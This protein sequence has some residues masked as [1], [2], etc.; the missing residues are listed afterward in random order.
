MELKSES[1]EL[2][3]LRHPARVRW[4]G[5]ILLPLMFITSGCVV[6]LPLIEKNYELTR[7]V[8]SLIL[9][10]FPFYMCIQAF[11]VFPF[12][13]SDVEFNSEG[14]GI[15]WTNGSKKDYL[16]SEVSELHYYATVQVLE[17]KDSSN[18]RILAVTGQATSY[19]QFV[20][21][22]SQKTGL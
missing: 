13:R 22:A 5:W 9:G 20:H 12:L 2:W 14:F 1:E 11:K 4:L 18:T 16:W 7:I 8:S 17:L 3:L 10:V 19:S 15:Y 21:F 6:L